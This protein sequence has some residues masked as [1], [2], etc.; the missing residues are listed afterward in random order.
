MVFCLCIALLGKMRTT[1]F[2]A[3][4]CFLALEA[5]TAHAAAADK[6]QNKLKLPALL[7][8]LGGANCR[9]SCEMITCRCPRADSSTPFRLPVSTGVR[10][11]GAQSAKEAISRGTES[12]CICAKQGIASTSPELRTDKV[13]HHNASSASTRAH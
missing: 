10:N 12:R 7:V 5:I 13:T 2:S 8:E 4:C 9:A 1:T 6:R 3:R 11:A